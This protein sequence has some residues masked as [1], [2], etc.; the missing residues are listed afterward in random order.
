MSLGGVLGGL[1]NA[2]IAPSI[3][4]GTAEYPLMMAVACLLRPR[5]AWP[6]RDVRAR[7]REVL[8]PAA[9]LLICGG[10]TWMLRWQATPL[11]QG[12]ADFPA[13]KMAVVASAVVAAFFLRR[14]PGYFG[15]GVAA[16]LAVSY[17]YPERG[18]RVLH[19][20]R[21]FFGVLRVLEDPS[22]TRTS[23]GT[24]R[25][26]TATKAST[27]TSDTNHRLTFIARDRSVGYSGRCSPD[28]HW[29]K[30]GCSG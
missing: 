27:R 29:P 26:P 3:F 6:L 15:V 22:G 8:L 25:Q 13:G 10:L 11:E 2:L 19:A 16:L 1:F 23:F 5:T 18:G 24:A 17:G 28:V 7:A 14:R 20:E 21:S 12:F 4:S 30:S 9:V